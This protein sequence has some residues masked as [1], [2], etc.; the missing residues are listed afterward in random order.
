MPFKELLMKLSSDFLNQWNCHPPSTWG[1]SIPSSPPTPTIQV[2]LPNGNS[3]GLPKGFQE[4]RRSTGS[5]RVVWT[6]V[7]H[8][9]SGMW[10]PETSLWMKHPCLHPLTVD[11]GL[12]HCYWEGVMS[13]LPEFLTKN[14]ESWAYIT[15][16]L[17]L[18]FWRGWD[19]MSITFPRGA[20]WPN[21][22][23]ENTLT[24]WEEKLFTT[25]Y[26]R[27][28]L[29]VTKGRNGFLLW[30][31]W[32]TEKIKKDDDGDKKGKKTNHNVEAEAHSEVDLVYCPCQG[33]LSERWSEFYLLVIISQ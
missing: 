9:K 2:H 5:E 1:L 17:P 28:Q 8:F 3:Q 32:S 4:N 6:H 11:F 13:F 31:Y 30:E 23:L 18:T 22:S 16:A 26:K 33:C 10:L 20:K 27:A 15:S 7:G 14:K 25:T 24:F 12:T 21:Y 19:I 29:T